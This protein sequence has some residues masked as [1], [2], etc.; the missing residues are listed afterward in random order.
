MVSSSI[1]GW[2]WCWTS[3]FWSFFSTFW[4]LG[5]WICT[6]MHSYRCWLSKVGFYA[7]WLNTLPT[8]LLPQHLRSLLI[9][10]LIFIS[11]YFSVLIRKWERGKPLTAFSAELCIIFRKFN[12]FMR[13]T[14][15]H[16]YNIPILYVNAYKYMSR[17]IY[18]HT[19]ADIYVFHTVC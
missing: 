7:C 2:G 12:L 3:D 6:T 19:C 4:L 5:L 13:M 14:N 15:R 17:L 18:L 9:L 11:K 8:E 16:K 10:S 1:Y